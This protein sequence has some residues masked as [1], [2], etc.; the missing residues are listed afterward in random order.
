VIESGIRTLLGAQS[1]ITNLLTSQTIGTVTFNGIF[2]QQAKQGFIPPF[3]AIK[4]IERDPMACLDGTVGMMSSDIVVSCVALTSDKAD[5]VAKAVTD[6]F[7]DYTGAAGS[8]TIDAVIWTDAPTDEIADP[9]G[10][11]V[12]W[13][14]V[15]LEFTV[16]HH[17]T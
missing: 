12:A 11:E 7:K 13:K 6:Y 3:I 17:T 5:A 14:S 1:S 4:R 16:Q 15:D 10:G 8:D 9:A 2:V